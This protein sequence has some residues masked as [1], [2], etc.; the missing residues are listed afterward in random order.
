[1]IELLVAKEQ[2]LME[3]EL[4]HEYCWH[5]FDRRTLL[6]TI[7]GFGY[8]LATSENLSADKLTEY[9]GALK[10]AWEEIGALDKKRS[11]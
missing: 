2:N 4:F 1:M 9:Q 6:T 7:E 5:D 8:L 11:I 3:E 10:Q